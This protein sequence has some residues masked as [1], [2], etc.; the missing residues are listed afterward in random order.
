MTPG[1]FLVI[2]MIYLTVGVLYAYHKYDKITDPSKAMFVL[3]MILW[4]PIM[5][6]K[7]LG[8][9]CTIILFMD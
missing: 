3:R 6:V 5:L 1:T 7:T 4:L 9:V 2:A 8:E